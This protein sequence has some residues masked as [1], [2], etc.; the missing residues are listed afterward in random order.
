MSRRSVVS[1]R[2]ALA[3]AG[4]ALSVAVAG[5]TGSSDENTNSDDRQQLRPEDWED[6]EEIRLQAHMR[7]FYGVEPAMIEDVRNPALLLFEG[8]EYEI[9][10]ENGD[11]VPHNFA[12]RD[13][14]GAT[15][16]GIS[17]RR[18]RERGQTQSV[19]VTATGEMH[20]YLCEPHPGTMTGYVHVR[21]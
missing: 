2:R 7:G 5:C 20:R 10:W 15:V 17:T 4:S 16:D 19:T 3:A 18:M 12:V 9:T 1:R 8:N 21:D 11:G 14:S 13:E 6:V